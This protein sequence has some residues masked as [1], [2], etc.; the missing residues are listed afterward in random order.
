[1]FN[2][3]LLA[4]FSMHFSLFILEPLSHQTTLKVFFF[5]FLSANFFFILSLIAL[6]VR[7][8]CLFE[9]FLIS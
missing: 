8:G 5:F 2:I 9:M 1:M 7:L 3:I 4:W 6:G